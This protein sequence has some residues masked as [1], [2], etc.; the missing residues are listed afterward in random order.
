MQDK[1]IKNRERDAAVTMWCL[2]VICLVTMICF[3]D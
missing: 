3:K 1:E 2:A